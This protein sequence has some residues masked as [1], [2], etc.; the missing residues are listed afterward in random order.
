MK[1]KKKKYNK[2]AVLVVGPTA[3]G[4]TK[5]AILVA[6]H[7][8][9]EIISADSRQCFK[10]MKTGT[11]VPSAAQLRT[12]PHH[13]IGSHSVTEQMNAGR[14]EQFAL[15]KATELFEK[16][17]IIVVSGGTG[18]YLKA[19]AEG[20]DP[21]P[22]SSK[23]IEQEIQEQY[24]E[25]G[26]SWLQQQ[27]QQ[28]DPEGF[29]LLEQRN[30]QRLMRALTIFETTGRSIKDFQTGQVKER[31]FNLVKVGLTLPKEAL[32]HRI[33][34]RSRQM[35]GQGLAEEAKRLYALRHL[36]AL[37][38]VGY[39]EMFDYLENNCSLEE[40]LQ[41]IIVHT[42]QYAKRQMTWFKKDKEIQWFSPEDA[43]KIIA[44]I[45]AQLTETA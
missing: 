21:I 30:P 44:Y 27:L 17:E 16:N 6:Q 14:F 8:N 15:H 10:E 35:I 25:K 38:T 36:N 40:A 20:I 1:K 4:K 34:K 13:F 5:V 39:K 9:A 12:V 41:Q 3:V 18:L 32:W 28:K 29:S 2:T 24:R 43:G 23:I 19:F 33:E 7:F 31:P 22:P 37:Q 26:L 11:A 45:E 42:R